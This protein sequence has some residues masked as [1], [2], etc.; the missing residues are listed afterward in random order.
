[1]LKT[2]VIHPVILEAL[3]EAGHGGKVLIADGDYP[4][5]TTRGIHAKVVHLN[6]V[7]GKMEATEVLDALQ[8]IL[9]IEKAQV[10]DVPEGHAKPEIWTMYEEMLKA[11]G[12]PGEITAL[13]RFAFYQ[14]VA[15][16]DTALVIQTGEIREYANLL[17]TIGSLW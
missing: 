17:L 2:Q 3:A 13:E 12:D 9:P 4:V 8:R 14:E 15:G 11:A 16:P 7:P 10:M 6:L 5:A 1:M